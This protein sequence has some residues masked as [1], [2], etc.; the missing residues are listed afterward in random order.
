MKS[1]KLIKRILVI[2]L[3]FVASIEFSCNDALIVY[4]QASL[5]ENTLAN[6]EGIESSLISAYAMLDG[7]G[8]SGFFDLTAQGD[9]WILGDVASDDCHKGSES[10]DFFVMELIEKFIWTPEN[11]II[12]QKFVALY[13]G[14]ARANA[15][16]RLI[17]NTT[18]L[19]SIDKDNL[20]G[21]A[22][23]L[24]AF[25]HF[26]L[27]K[28]W[29]NIPFIDE[30]ESDYRV[31]NDVDPFPQILQDLTTAVELLPEDRLT[32][33]RVD[34]IVGQAFLGKAYLF[35][36]QILEAQNQLDD[37]V[38]S[39]KHSL[40]NCYHDIF[41]VSLENG[42]ESLLAIQASVRDGTNYANEIGNGNTHFLTFPHNEFP[43]GCCGFQNPTQNLVNAYKV[44]DNGLPL[45]DNYNDNDLEVHE[46]VDPRLDWIV[47]RDNVP[48]LNWGIHRPTWIRQRDN[49]GPY[50]QKKNTYHR[51]AGEAAAQGNWP[52]HYS[53]LNIH[54]VRYADVL[55]MLAECEVEIGNLERARELVNMIRA[56]AGI[57]AQG[58]GESLETITAPIDDESITWTQY[59]VGLYETPW[60]D[61]STARKAVR[62]E[63]RLELALE[64]H[65]FFDLRRWGTAKEVI[66]NYLSVESQK[67]P[68]LQGTSGYE[69]HHR[70]YPLPALQ[71]ELSK[72]NG[73]AQLK[74]NEGY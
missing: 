31:P 6:K 33:G 45:L 59:K 56:R 36:G 50:S 34:R 29:G 63:R 64:G 67:R 28:I 18:D 16:L 68:F 49:Y 51:N 8:S 44:D 15:T 4:P 42:P 30:E 38:F 62:F 40:Q 57:C 11:F 65:R 21:E 46:Y 17:G 23:F 71:I 48:Y 73:V 47:G 52:V 26:E 54:L 5:D 61:Q 2:S 72:I 55:L 20:M 13:E 70:W 14:I 10:G 19:N 27:W 22:L 25:Y 66:N 41:S 7:I 58:S 60:T 1:K 35:D 39:G 9:N 69:D 12:N 74:Q 37:V 53:A 24:R 32:A 43:I 3:L